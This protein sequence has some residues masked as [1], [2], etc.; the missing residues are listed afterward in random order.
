[1]ST[2][3]PDD[4]PDGA[5]G[6]P[7]RGP[8][9]TSATHNVRP[10]ADRLF[11]GE[12]V[13]HGRA[14]LGFKDGGEASYFVTLRSE[15]GERTLWGRGLERALRDARTR[16]MP[17]DQIGVREN[18]ID[19]ASVVVRTRNDRGHVVEEKRYETPRPHWVVEKRSFFDERLAMARTLRD[20]RV[21]R[22][23][24]TRNHPE[25]AGSYWVIDSAVKTAA[26][27]IR[28]P[29]NREAFVSLVREALA[30]TAERGEPLPRHPTAERSKSVTTRPTHSPPDRDIVR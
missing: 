25:L 4:P 24:A 14:P 26:E 3:S 1:M 27:R 15:R 28:R 30:Y 11:V 6:K 17:G 13:R 9:P 5:A 8:A 21:S 22:G 16:P 10:I 20:P 12:L 7:D 18:S 29:E 2:N 19:P 23:E